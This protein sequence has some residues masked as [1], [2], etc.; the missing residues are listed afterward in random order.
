MGSLK[1]TKI[2][3]NYRIAELSHQWFQMSHLKQRL[4]YCRKAGF[5]PLSN[6]FSL[7][8]TEYVSNFRVAALITK[9]SNFL[10]DRL[11]YTENGTIFLKTV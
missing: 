11:L 9:Q 3:G 1:F 4:F 6:E 2:T 5:P 8:H 7:Y 10:E